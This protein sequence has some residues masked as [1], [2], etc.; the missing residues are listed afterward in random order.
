MKSIFALLSLSVLS[1]AEVIMPGGG[2][3]AHIA[4]G[5]GITMTITVVNL[6]DTANTWQLIL[7]ADS[8]A[9]LPLA[10]NFGTLSTFGG[11]LPPHGSL[12]INTLGAGATAAQGWAGL[13]T[14][15][16]VGGSVVFKVNALPWSGSET[17]IPLDTD[18]NDRFALI[19]DHT[20]TNTTGLAMTNPSRTAAIPVTITFK[21]QNGA[22]I[23]TKSFS[24]PPFTHTTSVA[25]TDF[26]ATNGK[27]GTVEIST[28]GVMS[29]LGLRFGPTAVSSILPLVSNSWVPAASPSPGPYGY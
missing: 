9:L 28:S 29:V 11:T 15:G 20:G 4:D 5:G 14:S 21:D 12:T 3:I 7:Y 2:V 23:A 25:T 18:H 26:P 8:G 22:V 13:I 19:F 16:T 17:L 6:D 10:T 27:V 1:Y 24:M